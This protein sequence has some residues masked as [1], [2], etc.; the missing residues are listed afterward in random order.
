MDWMFA[1]VIVLCIGL[2]AM[3][4]A[5]AWALDK[6]QPPMKHPDIDKI[7]WPIDRPDDTS[8]IERRH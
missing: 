2:A 6:T 4:V 8:L 3:I 5:L 1:V 7:Q